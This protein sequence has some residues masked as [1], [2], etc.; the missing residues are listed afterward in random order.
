MSDSYLIKEPKDNTIWYENIMVTVWEWMVQS[1]YAPPILPPNLKIVKRTGCIVGGKVY[2]EPKETLTMGALEYAY[3][4]KNDNQLNPYK[5][6]LVIY[7]DNILRF[8]DRIFKGDIT[9]AG[10][11]AI[12]THTMIHEL[13]HYISFYMAWQLSH[14]EPAENNDLP[15]VPYEV[16]THALKHYVIDEF[17]T[18]QDEAENEN[19]T[20]DIMLD[21]F[22]LGPSH[23]EYK[24][25]TK[26]DVKLARKIDAGEVSLPDNLTYAWDGPYINFYMKRHPKSVNKEVLAIYR[27]YVSL[28]NK[29]FVTAELTP[30]ELDFEQQEL[31]RA[32]RYI[33]KR[34]I[35]EHPIIK[36]ADHTFDDEYPYD[37]N[38]LEIDLDEYDF[39]KWKESIIDGN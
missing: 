2:N 8:V 27:I 19:K 36:V 28:F 1:G 33:R 11:L 3:K 34:A 37:D 4:I 5:M 30:R 32:A 10:F 13:C 35:D 15:D 6:S 21:F 9:T 17:G 22:K 39:K 18:V 16:A 24:R 20:L 7:H 38:D 12:I 14:D 23:P 25:F 26:E 31:Y 29:R